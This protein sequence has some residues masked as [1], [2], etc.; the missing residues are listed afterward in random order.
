MGG[1]LPELPEVEAWRRAIDAWLVGRTLVDVQL[2]DPAVVRPRLSTR[3][4]D[5]WSEAGAWV[6]TLRG[7]KVRATARAGKRLGVQVGDQWVL[8][9]LGMTGRFVRGEE[10]RSARVCLTPDDGPPVWFADQRRFGCW[11][12]LADR[13]ALADGL[14]PDALGGGLDATV[15]RDQLKGRSAVKVALLDQAR[16]A[17]LGNIHA[18]EALWRSGIAPTTRCAELTQGQLER[19]APAIVAQLT[20]A[21]DDIGPVD[22]FVYVTEGGD[23]PFAV[24]GR[25]GE[26]CPRCDTAVARVVQGGRSTFWCPRCQ[27]A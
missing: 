15:L 27:P 13:S 9:H 1:P 20:E 10:P 11:V 3:P 14:G 23:N 22:D 26:P 7:A 25:E 2:L 24:Y 19:L 21:V 17:G 8:V 4:A 5:A 6:R 18:A 12:P 16:L